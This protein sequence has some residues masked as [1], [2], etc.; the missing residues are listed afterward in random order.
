MKFL[1]GLLGGLLTGFIIGI[2]V[3]LIIGVLTYIWPTCACA[4]DMFCSVL[5]CDMNSCAD[6]ACSNKYNC[7][8]LN[9]ETLKQ[10]KYLHTFIFLLTLC[11]LAGGVYGVGLA[12]SEQNEKSRRHELEQRQKNAAML[13]SEINSV[14]MNMQSIQM[15]SNEYS[16]IPNYS[17]CEKQKMIWEHLNAAIGSNEKLREIIADLDF[18]DSDKEV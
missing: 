5:T 7:D 17:S 6:A 16:L 8:D 9:K 14:T 1:G 10:P 3:A 12:I 15:N 4:G 13:K 2:G 18:S 11:T